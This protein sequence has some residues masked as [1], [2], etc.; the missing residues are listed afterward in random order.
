MF[1][2]L[3]RWLWGYVDF[4]AEGRFPER[5]INLSARNG[6]RLWKLRGSEQEIRGCA[7]ESEV[8]ALTAAAAK[9][10][11]N[12]MII[13]RHGMPELV[14]KYRIRSGLLAGLVLAVIFCRYMSGFVWNIR[15]ELPDTIN[16]YEMRSLLSEN[17]FSEGVN[18]KNCKVKDLINKVSL[19]DSRISWM[20]V[21][22][23]GSNAD[24]RVSPNLADSIDKKPK[25]VTGNLKSKADGTVTRVIVRNGS[26][27]IKAG[28]GIRKDQLLVSGVLEYNNGTT[29][30]VDS[31]AKVFAKTARTVTLTLNKEQTVF[32][33]TGQQAKKTQIRIFGTAIPM[34]PVSTPVGHCTKTESNSQ[35]TLLNGSRIPV[36]LE[37]ENWQAYEKKYT[38][39]NA[40][41][42]KELLEKKLLIYEF[43]MINDT[44]EGTILRCENNFS[45]EGDRFIMKA[46]YEIEENVCIKAPLQLNEEQEHDNHE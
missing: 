33:K 3:L 23:Q 18:G 28:D 9:T 44:D 34:S 41:Q 40:R 13:K 14:R 30:V 7:R 16:E 25:D 32:Q 27:M 31:E 19:L 21:N 2:K 36:L 10:Q 8:S 1:V 38:E 24:V 45:D 43:F 4:S 20:A 37:S 11:N 35:M 6:I 15:C 29:I 39:L 42:A 46:D 12:V 26:A 5:L 22:I 17:G